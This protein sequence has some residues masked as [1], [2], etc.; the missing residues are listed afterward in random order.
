MKERFGPVWVMAEQDD[1]KVEIVSLQLLGKARELAD[2]L[3]VA[4]EAVLLG[5]NLGEAA[6]R[7]IAFGADR[8]FLGDS[9]VLG[10]YQP[11]LWRDILC[12]LVNEHHPEVVLFGSTFV[13]RE[14][15]PLAAARLKTGLAA[16]CTGLSLDKDRNLEQHIPAYGG[17]MSIICPERRP[18]M[19]TVAKGVFKAPEP[20]ESRRGK[21]LFIKVPQEIPLPVRNLEIIRETPPGV[22]LEEADI[23]VCGGAGVGGIE[24]WQTIRE[25]AEILG[26]ALGCTRPVVDEGWAPLDAMI[27]QSGKMV[28]PQVYLGVGVSGE[29][30]HMVGVVGAKFMAAINNDPKSAIFHQVDLGIVEDCREFLPI[31]IE[32]IKAHRQKRLAC[33]PHRD[34]R[35]SSK[36]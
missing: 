23:V 10:M 26:A 11:L 9:P 19:A 4:C 25:L 28:S 2:G 15:A 3:G 31:L 35:T 34:P 1:C 7:L 17:I 24:G 13:G 20:D 14:L 32:K 12:S 36:E 18:Q 29:Q 5:H 30:Q 6:R 27:G 21:I 22:P 33:S 8:V 16:H